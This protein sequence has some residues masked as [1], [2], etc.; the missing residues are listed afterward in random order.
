MNGVLH[1]AIVVA[2]PPV[3]PVTITASEAEKVSLAE[4]YGLQAVRGLSA[5]LEVK[6]IA[7]G[8]EV[9]GHVTADVVQ[10]C[11]VSLVPVDERIDE[12]FTIRY[13]REA[14]RAP[15]P[16]EEFV[17][18]ADMPDPPDLLEGPTLDLG[19]VAEEQFALA[20]NP[21]P[22]APGAELPAEA[23]DPGDAADSP[24]AVLSALAKSPKGRG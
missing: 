2:D 23:S 16:D 14:P 19:S 6:P 20:L 24:F 12:T 18:D 13:T 1:H 7:D 4:E 22:R 8:V 17:L 9:D 10:T 21:Y 5:T 11:V 15:R 3:G